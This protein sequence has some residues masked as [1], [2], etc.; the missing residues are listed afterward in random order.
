MLDMMQMVPF[1][2]ISITDLCSRLR[3]PRKAFYRYF[4]DKEG[5]LYS[6]IDHTMMEYEQFATAHHKEPRTLNGD[7]EKFFLFWRTRKPLLDALSRSQISHLLVHRAICQTVD[8]TGISSRF[9][10]AD[11]ETVRPHIIR[12]ALEGLLGM[13]LR[14]YG[15]GFA[16]SPSDLAVLAARL[17]TK[18]LF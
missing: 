18:P 10:A 2:Q 15:D 11:P 16:E 12:F 9:L 4:T 8:Y 17:L 13:V 14:W 5:A 7:L 6:L 1:D 3:I